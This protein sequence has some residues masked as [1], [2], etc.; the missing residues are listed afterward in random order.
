[1]DKNKEIVY[2]EVDVDGLCKL[3]AEEEWKQITLMTPIGNLYTTI[4]TENG[5]RMEI[6]DEWNQLYWSLVKEY[7]LLCNQYAKYPVPEEE[8]D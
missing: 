2:W 1:M 6:A 8:I 5:V 3:L 7:K 4:A